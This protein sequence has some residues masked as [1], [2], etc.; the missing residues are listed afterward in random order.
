MEKFEV[1]KVYDRR[2]GEKENCH[3]AHAIVMDAH[4]GIL[5]SWG[6]ITQVVCPRSSL[7]FIQALPLV[8]TGAANA[9]A[10]NEAFLTLS[11]AS[12]NGETEHC[13]K[14]GS[15]LSQ[16]GLL[17]GDLECGGHWPIQREAEH[18]LVQSQE[19]FCNVHNNCSG[20]HAGMLSV[21]KHM[22]WP[23]KG[24]TEAKHDLQL[25]IKNIISEMS[26]TPMDQIKTV[27][28]GCSAPNYFLPFENIARMFSRF[29]SGHG[30]SDKRAQACQTL[31]RAVV[32]H[33]Y[34]IAG[35][36]RFCS[37]LVAASQGDLLGKVGAMG[38][39]I[40]LAPKAQKIIYA[41][42]EDGNGVAVETVICALMKR[43]DLWSDLHEQK[44]KHYAQPIIKNCREL[45]VGDICVVFPEG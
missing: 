37:D 33:P 10:L 27:I 18:E 14:V 4:G 42:I 34:L 35:K 25:Y 6:D 26:D 22:G 19:K 29:M 12:H 23:L 30:L 44:I 36:K 15:W 3:R 16:L 41:K 38:N 39:F 21:C 9:L 8:E 5:E 17:D 40:L 13:E 45:D 28:D 7:K 11:C 32:R 43:F 2:G 1:I 31:M 24:Y 20:K